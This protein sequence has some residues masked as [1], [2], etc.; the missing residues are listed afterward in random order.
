M[1]KLNDFFIDWT[2]RLKKVCKVHH[3]LAT[4]GEEKGEDSGR[5]QRGR[6]VLK[7]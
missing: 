6:G 3:S 5:I 1:S 7:G 2:N 4:G